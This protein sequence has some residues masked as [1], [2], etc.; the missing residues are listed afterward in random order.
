MIYREAELR[1]TIQSQEE[2]TG[3]PWTELQGAEL[4]LEGDS[5]PLMEDHEAHVTKV[6]TD[7]GEFLLVA[8]NMDG[9]GVLSIVEKIK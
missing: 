6:V 8:Q 4:H 9:H 1:G 5:Y 2:V 7:K 3:E